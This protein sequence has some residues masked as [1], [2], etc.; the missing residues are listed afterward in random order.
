MADETNTS[1]ALAKLKI[2]AKG[3][4]DTDTSKVFN[5]M[6][7]PVAFTQKLEIELASTQAS[8]SSGNENKFLRMKPV[9]F[10][11]EFILDGTGTAAPAPE[12]GIVAEIDKLLGICYHIEGENHKPNYVEI[13]WGSLK[14]PK[15]GESIIVAAF[16]SIDINY[17]MFKPDG[18]PIRAKINAVFTE[19]IPKETQARDANNQSPDL[20]K[21][22][23]ISTHSKLPLMVNTEYN[24]Q[25]HCISIAKAN[26]L[27][28]MRRLTTGKFLRM[29]PYDKSVTK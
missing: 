22:R 1:Q 12:N 21:Y 13:Q 27:D 15:K 26:K 9:D 11:F 23:Q 29:P 5:V 2:K 25:K 28:S 8:G 6:F 16:K 7:N 17:T 4:S 19:E 18:T 10:T 3:A 20:T 14:S 24:T